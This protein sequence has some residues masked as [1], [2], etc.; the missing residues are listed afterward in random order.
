MLVVCV[1]SAAGCKPGEPGEPVAVQAA[2]PAGDVTSGAVQARGDACRI[3]MTVPAE[4]RW[5]SPWDPR[6][7]EPSGESP[8]SAHSVYWASAREKETLRANKTAMPLD[9]N[10]HAPGPPAIGLSLAAF[11]S[12][13]KDFPLAP[14]T[15]RIVGKTGGE[16][17]PGEVL[18]GALLFDQHEY[19]ATGGTLV[20]ERFDMEGVAGTFRIDGI[21]SLTGKQRLHIEGSF[22]IPCHGGMLESECRTNKVKATVAHEPAARE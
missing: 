7:V 18:A 14:G 12:T 19:D 6:G 22:E 13:E 2:A 11:S 9:I 20:I 15:Y 16:V 17:Q 5:T 21:E 1:L 8:S 3:H 4:H 10:C